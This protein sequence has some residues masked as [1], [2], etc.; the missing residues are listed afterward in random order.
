MRVDGHAALSRVARDAVRA[1]AP[2]RRPGA[3]VSMVAASIMCDR[4]LGG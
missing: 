2:G 3:P 4:Q 1:A